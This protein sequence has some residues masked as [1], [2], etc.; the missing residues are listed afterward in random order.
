MALALTS[1]S[2]QKPKA[3]LPP[4]GAL[5]EARWSEILQ[6]AEDVFREKGYR[7]TTIQEIASRVGIMAG[8]LYYYIDNKQD[9]LYHVLVRISDEYLQGLEEVSGISEGDARSRLLHFVDRFMAELDR[10]PPW[11]GLTDYDSVFLEADQR[12][13]LNARR[14]Q[15]NLL[16]KSIIATG[17]AEGAFDPTID[18]SVAT[19]GILCLMTTTVRWHQPAGRTSL[20]G[21]TEWY[22][23]FILKGLMPGAPEYFGRPP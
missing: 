5:N 3:K 13:S 11:S 17:M 15:I 2:K 4:K 10:E 7:A 9:I 14:H 22:K 16:L 20:H 19:N 6:V 8:S 21:V 12:D 23:A 1:R 18:P